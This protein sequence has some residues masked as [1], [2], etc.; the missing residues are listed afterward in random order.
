M[1]SLSFV[2][3]SI[4]LLAASSEAAARVLSEESSPASCLTAAVL[5]ALATEAAARASAAEASASA[6]AASTAAE[7]RFDVFAPSSS[8]CA[9]R[10]LLALSESLSADSRS[11][12][13]RVEE[14]ASASAAAA[15]L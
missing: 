4:S 10:A 6:V 5:S 7:T 2:S 14:A 1:A 3:R 15:H 9:S 13:R 12:M 8:S 11:S